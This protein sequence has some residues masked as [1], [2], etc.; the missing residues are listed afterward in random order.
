MSSNHTQ[1]HRNVGVVAVEAVEAPE[2]VTSAW[3]DEQLAEVFERCNVRPGLLEELAGI[4][5][6]RWWPEEMRFDRAAALAGEQAIVA[7]GIDRGKI[8]MLISTSVCKHH[9][10]PSVACAVHHHLELA[11]GCL[12]FDLGNA[13]LGF[14][15]AIHL[16]ATAIDAGQ[17]EYALIVDG[18]GARHTHLTTIARLQAEAFVNADV[19]DEFASLTLGSGAAAMVLGSLDANPQAHRFVGGVSRAATQH[20]DICVGD[21]DRMRTDT[22]ALLE[23][24]LVLAGEA[25]GASAEAFGWQ[26]GISWYVLHQVSS[27]HTSLMCATLGIDEARAPLTFPLHGN[28][29]PASIPFT[30]AG[31][32]TEI[33]AGERVLCLG[34]GSGL[35]ASVAEIVW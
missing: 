5:E 1:R 13:C 28:I 27:V 12:N 17:I 9:L 23:G 2:I 11:P 6:R 24:G 16:A 21:L 31:V 7:A 25:W 29:G 22:K 32:Q 30:L 10:E 4:R 14:V 35:N 26:E 3:I 8:G 15:N 19:Y 20:H 18:E 33:A 34:M